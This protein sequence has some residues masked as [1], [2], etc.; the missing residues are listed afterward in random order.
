MKAPFEKTLFHFKKTSNKI[1][2]KKQRNY[3]SQV[4]N[5]LQYIKQTNLSQIPQLNKS[6]YQ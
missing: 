6:N 2:F 1:A 3:I 5:L 4:K